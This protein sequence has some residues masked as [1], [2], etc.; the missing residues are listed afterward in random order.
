MFS[1]LKFF[2][3]QFSRIYFKVITHEKVFDSSQSN[4]IVVCIKKIRKLKNIFLRIGIQ[5]EVRYNRV[6]NWFYFL[7]NN[8]LFINRN[9]RMTKFSS[10]IDFFYYLLD[11]NLKI[12][13]KH[14]HRHV[15][16][17]SYMHI[18]TMK[19]Y[20]FTELHRHISL[21]EIL[22]YFRLIC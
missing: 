10:Q 3:R 15:R 22:Y 17:F 1:F 21:A 18:S 4:S 8:C 11:S 7:V 14:E 19:N 6:K 13:N 16:Q 12:F 5:K 9:L 20:H 2:S